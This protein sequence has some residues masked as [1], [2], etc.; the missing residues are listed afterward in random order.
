MERLQAM[1]RQSYSWRTTVAQR[2]NFASGA[3]FALTGAFFSIPAWG[4]VA[5]RLFGGFSARVIR[6]FSRFAE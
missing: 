6:S 1:G 5:I 3:F 2:F 4:R